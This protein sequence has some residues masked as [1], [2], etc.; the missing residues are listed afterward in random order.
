MSTLH[1][2]TEFKLKIKNVSMTGYKKFDFKLRTRLILHSRSIEQ[3][4]D[5]PYNPRHSNDIFNLNCLAN[6]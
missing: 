6:N 2:A 4:S 1:Y 3:V 5:L